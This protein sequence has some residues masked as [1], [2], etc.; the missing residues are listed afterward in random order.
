MRIKHLSRLFVVFLLTGLALT[1]APVM[2]A[3]TD[4]TIGIPGKTGCLVCHGDPKLTQVKNRQSLYISDVELMQSVHK[5]LACVKCHTDFQESSASKSHQGQQTDS[6]KVAGLSCKNCHEHAPQLK[7]FDKSVHGRASLGGDAKAPTCADCHGAHGI[8]SFKK[9]K[10][11]KAEFRTQAN[12]VCGKCHKDYY[13]SYNDYYHGSAYKTSAPDAPTCWD[14]HGAHEILPAGDPESKVAN[15]NLARTCGTC[16][17]DSHTAF[18]KFAALIHGRQTVMKKNLIMKYK[19]LLVT[20][21]NETVLGQ[22]KTAEA[23]TK[24]A[25]SSKK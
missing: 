12:Q 11:Y 15:K 14:C 23:D 17:P 4:F 13:E 3:P 9:N 2:A 25:S 16:H 19:D 7:V 6:K 21:F 18:T 10:T 1:Q 22:G 24:A 20:W 8:K 5:D